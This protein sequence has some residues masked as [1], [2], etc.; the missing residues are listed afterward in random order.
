MNIIFYPLKAEYPKL[1]YE[2]LEFLMAL[3]LRYSQLLHMPCQTPKA[4][5]VYEEMRAI[6]Q[7]H[8]FYIR[9]GGFPGNANIPEQTYVYHCSESYE[10]DPTTLNRKIDNCS[11]ELASACKARLT[12]I[13][14]G[15][16]GFNIF[17][18]CEK[19]KSE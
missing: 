13:K 11:Y 7:L 9:H 18:V 4:P 5:E 8:I 3:K 1:S 12:A 2:Q 14:E 6:E 19:C 10:V 16:E 15:Y 17:S